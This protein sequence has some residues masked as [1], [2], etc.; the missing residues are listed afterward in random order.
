MSLFSSVAEKS[1][2]LW[3]LMAP[4]D[5]C[6]KEETRVCLL[7][8]VFVSRFSTV[9]CGAAHGAA[10]RG[11]TYFYLLTVRQVRLCVGV[12]SFNGVVVSGFT[13]GS[14]GNLMVSSPLM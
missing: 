3:S 11:V 6:K 7:V 1:C 8:L 5:G 12:F 9:A 10:G 13:S 4:V 2:W 14:T